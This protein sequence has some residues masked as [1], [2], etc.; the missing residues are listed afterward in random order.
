MPYFGNN[1]SPLL[2]NTVAQNGKEMTLDADAD[3]SITADTDDQIDIKIGGADD[4][5]FTAN[6]FTAQSGSTIAAQALTATTITTSSTVDINGNELILDAD[7]DTSITADTD[8]QIDIKIAGADDFQFTA[9]TFTAQSG[10][11]IAAQALTATTISA[12]G[13]ISFDGGDFVFNESGASKDF[14]V[15]GDTNTNLLLVDGSADRVGINT[16]SPDAKLDIEGTTDAELRVTRTTAN[17]ASN[18]ADQGAV[19]N[20]VN[21]IEFENG[22][23]GDAYTGQILFTSNDGSTGAG[24]RAKIAVK[25]THYAH[26]ERLMFHV[27]PQNTA[28]GISTA[29]GHDGKAV[30][31]YKGS[32][33]TVFHIGD[34]E[35]LN[36]G[37]GYNEATLC[38]GKHFGIYSD[39]NGNVN[40]SEIMVNSYNDGSNRVFATSGRHAQSIQFDTYNGNM[41][42]RVSSASGNAD[43]NVSFRN[44]LNIATSTGSIGTGAMSPSG[45]AMIIDNDSTTNPFGLAIR[46]PNVAIDNNTTY[47][48]SCQDSAAERF[49]VF[50]DGDVSTSDAG[51]LSSDEKLKHTITDATD[52]WEDVKKLQVRNFY[53]K[54]D[55]HPTKKDHK[56]IGFIAQEFET[57]FPKLVTNIKDT[58]LVQEKDKDGVFQQVSKETGTTTKH[59]KEGKLIPILTKALQEAMARIETLETKVKTLE[60][61]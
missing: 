19:L 2:L 26:F 33:T 61:A 29:T 3:T 27:S 43:A 1:P 41:H 55:Y 15:E 17:V 30:E 10:S 40:T 25:N 59:I 24:V 32:E 7:G 35:P 46:T 5:Q 14:R 13:D 60:E 38:V 22:Y 31:I 39:N 34:S 52:K 23:N 9:N 50:S 16:S 54:E 44:A 49:K 21:N 47:F 28:T 42:L 18:F 45:T 56:M 6:T 48:I 4:F 8:D 57:V 36:I 20:L 11:T 53:W 12:T 51:V 58:E 37:T